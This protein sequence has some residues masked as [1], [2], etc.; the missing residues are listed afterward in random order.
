M[1]LTGNNPV[2]H[3]L[4]PQVIAFV[5]MAAFVLSA[6][7]LFLWWSRIRFS[8]PLDLVVRSFGL[9]LIGM[10]WVVMVLFYFTTSGPIGRLLHSIFGWF[11]GLMVSC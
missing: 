7:P 3:T 10:F 4:P 6:S 11:T 8:C 2:L 9:G 1:D 5:A